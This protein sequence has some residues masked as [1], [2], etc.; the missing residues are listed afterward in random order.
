LSL[1][2]VRR[3]VVAALVVCATA[4]APAHAAPDVGFT[5]MSFSDAQ[6]GWAVFMTPC[7]SG[8]N[9]ARV[10]STADGGR[11]WQQL[12]AR[13]H[14]CAGVEAFL[15][16]ATAHRVTATL[17]FVSGRQ[18]MMTIDG[19]HNWTRVAMPY[20]EAFTAVPG[21]VFV[22]T[23]TS[24]GCP[25]ACNVMLRRAAIGAHEF[26]PVPAFRNPTQGFGDALVGAG[27][28][29]YAV[30]FGR[31]AG[32]AEAAY[33]RLSISR[34]GGRTWSLRGDPCRVPGGS[35]FDASQL[36]AAG[37]YVAVLCRARGRTDTS[38]VLSR[39]AGRTFARVN[40]PVA[41]G[42]AIELA[43]N[44][45]IAVVNILDGGEGLTHYRLALSHNLGRT[46]R[47]VVRSDERLGPPAWPSI[48]II[49]RSIRALIGRTLWRSD[50]AGK[51]WKE[52]TRAW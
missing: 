47:I 52:S 1:P 35:E 32:G 7:G 44:G 4:I 26:A 39:D 13:L 2:R 27:P 5:G 24:G 37:R 25:L 43:A 29:L 9:C 14:V 23:S 8:V 34:D 11:V 45:T 49:G 46:W 38:L 20:V 18:T 40:L 15:C 19:G 3:I 42:A 33:A 36:A 28:N 48:R 41:H 10:E 30:G 22:L 51:T 6:N 17:G 21:G 31:P 16:E 12:A 50:D